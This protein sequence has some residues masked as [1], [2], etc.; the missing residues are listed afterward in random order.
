MQQALDLDGGSLVE[1]FRL[2]SADPPWQFGDKLPGP[3]RGAEKHYQTLSLSE[4]CAFPLP[5]VATDAVLALWRV[6]SMQEE[7]FAV[8][9]AWGFKVKAEMVWKKLTPTG[10]RWFGMGR[11]VRMEHEIVLLATRGRPER[12]RADVRSVFEAQAG[13][14]SEKPEAF[15]EILESLYDGPYVE[16]FARRQRDGW[17]CLGNE[18]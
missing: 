2:I 17:T 10:K 15:Y 13:R 18:L 5:P 4:L 7:A 9:K 6:A 11:Q 16:L 3:K 12:K 8:A 1:P 14:H